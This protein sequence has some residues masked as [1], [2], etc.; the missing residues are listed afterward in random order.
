VYRG[1]DGQWCAFKTKLLG[2]C[3]QI[4]IGFPTLKAAKAWAEKVRK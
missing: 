3:R 2:R 1:V 4:R